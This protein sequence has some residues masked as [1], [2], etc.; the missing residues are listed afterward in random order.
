MDLTKI[1]SISTVSRKYVIG[2]VSFV[3]IEGVRYDYEI[4]R[5]TGPPT[6]SELKYYDIWCNVKMNK[7]KEHKNVLIM[8]IPFHSITE[9]N[10]LY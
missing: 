5:I 10:Y 1:K 6:T 8:R 2:W 9:V 3:M 4:V 7:I